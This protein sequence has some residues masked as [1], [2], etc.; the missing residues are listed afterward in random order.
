MATHPFAGQWNHSTRHYPLLAET[1]Q[2]HH[3]ILDLGCG[4]GVLSRY[5]AGLGHQVIGV[6]NDLDVLPGDQPGAHFMLADAT[7]LPFG[8][9]SFDA[10]VSVMMLHHTRMEMALAEMRRVLKP[11]GVIAI[12]GI[13]RD[14]TMADRLASAADII[15]CF[16]AALGK[17]SWTSPAVTRNPTR[18]WDE[19]RT[20]INEILPGARWNRLRGWRYLAIWTMASTT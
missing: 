11:G 16:V 17:T 15:P 20:I 18:G 10:V 4:E 6:D 13:A 2:G 12:L 9:D 14:L 3:T 8:Y 7:G 1:L 5:L 19:T